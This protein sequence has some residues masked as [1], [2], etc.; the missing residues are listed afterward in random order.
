MTER[1]TWDICPRCG[2]YAAVGWLDGMPVGFDCPRGCQLTAG[3]F[4]RREPRGGGA[5]PSL[6]DAPIGARSQP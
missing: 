1:V 6:T 3:E 2:R 5:L 4:G